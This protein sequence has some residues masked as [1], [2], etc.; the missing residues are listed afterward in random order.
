ME[1]PVATAAFLESAGANASGDRVLNLMVPI[2]FFYWRPTPLVG[3]SC[4]RT[5]CAGNSPLS[6]RSIN[7]SQRSFGIC[8]KERSSPV[9]SA[10]HGSART[11]P[12]RLL[13]DEPARRRFLRGRL[14]HRTI[15][16]PLIGSN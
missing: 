4:S 9:R 6:I 16:H 8:E 11:V 7:E 10:L 5:P 3:Y 14:R 2:H 15:Q 13:S 1:A 12:A